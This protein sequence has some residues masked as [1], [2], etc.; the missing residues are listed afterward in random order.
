VQA[1]SQ[2]QWFFFFWKKTISDH[3]V[4]QILAPLKGLTDEEN[5]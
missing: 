2:G 1:K 3:H 5:M 4:K